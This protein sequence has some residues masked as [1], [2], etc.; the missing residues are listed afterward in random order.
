M[1]I[2]ALLWDFG[3]TLV[4]ERWMLRPPA[5]FANWP[6]VW[7]EVVTERAH[8][9]N[10][11]HLTEADI[12]SDLAT[13]TGMER[14]AIERHA[15]ACCRSIQFH[16]AAW[17]AVTE[18]RLPQA[19]VTV[20]PDLFVERVARPYALAEHFDAVIVSCI[21]GTDD[22]NELCLIALDRLGFAGPRSEGLLVDNRDDLTQAWIR[23]GG[24]AYHFQSDERFEIDW[25]RMLGSAP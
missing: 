10:I 4:D 5:D 13:R 20:N 11:G 16:T 21:E 17:R 23:V 8:D 6:A 18:R 19:L 15:A 25:P 9:W 3:D 24:S 7:S 14:V 2:A 22:K 1:T 12:F